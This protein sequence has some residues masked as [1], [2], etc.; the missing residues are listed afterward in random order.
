MTDQ[1]PR[2]RRRPDVLLFRPPGVYRAQSD[3]AVLAE[4][5]RRGGYALGR[6]V[7]DV[8]TGSGA[9]ALASARAGAASVTAVD[10]SLRSV[11]AT[12]VNCHL[13]GARVSVRRGDLFAPVSGRRFDLIVA[14][15]PY[16]PA[17]T[18]VLPRHTR[19]RCWDG[20]VDGRIVVDRICAGA[21]ERLTRGGVLLMVHSAVCGAEATIDRLTDAGM[22]AS[23]V[24]R[25]SIPYGPVMRERAAMMERRGLTG[26]GEDVEELVVVEGRRAG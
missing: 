18:D 9:L 24:M 10:L 21:G 7:L 2:L 13:H 14:N 25:A 26:P 19:A 12:W 8:G 5:I 1:L 22:S 11:L 17:E 6:H 15:P 20:G 3:S 4:A 23:V 16:V